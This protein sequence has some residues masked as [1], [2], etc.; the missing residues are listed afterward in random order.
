MADRSRRPTSMEDGADPAD[1]REWEELPSQ[2]DLQDDLGYEL[3]DLE[4]YE[5][6]EDRIVVLPKDEDMIREDAFIVVGKD[7]FRR[8]AE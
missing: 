2:P 3:C 4:T 5:A 7:D 8:V 6:E 1:R